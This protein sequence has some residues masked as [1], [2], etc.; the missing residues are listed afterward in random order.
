MIVN[1][2]FIFVVILVIEGDYAKWMLVEV[3]TRITKINAYYIQF[4]TF[5]YLRVADT[6]VNANKLP[7]YPYDRLIL[8][9]IARKI[10]FVYVKVRK[11]NKKTR[12]WPITI[13]AFEVKKK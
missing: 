1:D 5:T 6:L 10:T 2:C 7:I 11:Q 3:A 9:E 13:G 8:M 4:K 12:V